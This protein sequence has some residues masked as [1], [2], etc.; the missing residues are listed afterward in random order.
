MGNNDILIP[1]M[2]ADIEESAPVV[3]P[4]EYLKIINALSEI[5]DSGA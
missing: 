1:G 5:K 4:E 3:T 2:P